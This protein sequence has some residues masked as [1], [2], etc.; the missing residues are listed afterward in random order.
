MAYQTSF[1]CCTPLHAL[2]HHPHAF[3]CKLL[4]S[5]LGGPFYAS[6]SSA[7]CKTLFSFLFFLS[8]LAHFGLFHYQYV[9][10]VKLQHT[11]LNLNC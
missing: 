11:H 5:A 4:L 1:H 6:T 9:L 8:S 7:N 2:Q 3:I 10:A